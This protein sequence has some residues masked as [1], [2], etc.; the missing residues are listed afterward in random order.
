MCNG[1]I[2]WATPG[3]PLWHPNCC[4]HCNHT[5][6]KSIHFISDFYWTALVPSC[7]TARLFVSQA[8]PWIPVEHPNHC[9]CCNA[10][11]AGPI[12]SIL[13]F[14]LSWPAGVQWHAQWSTGPVRAF[15]QSV[16][17]FIVDG[18]WCFEFAVQRHRWRTCS[19]SLLVL[20]MKFAVYH[21]YNQRH[22][23]FSTRRT[24]LRQGY[25]IHLPYATLLY[26]C[27]SMV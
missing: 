6:A 11:N 10:T 21:F 23:D 9:R 1:K 13:S 14:M 26:N 22:E 15:P 4:G 17:Q 12:R 7:A 2:I 20:L 19:V 18:L 24:G 16:T 5:I 8:F 25:L 27:L 3:I